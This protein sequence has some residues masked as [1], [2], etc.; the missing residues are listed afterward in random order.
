V[1]ARYQMSAPAPPIDPVSKFAVNV[2]FSVIGPVEWV[3]G[4]TGKI[5]GTMIPVKTFNED[6]LFLI[7][8]GSTAFEDV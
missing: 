5:G 1:T 6:A 3:T 7:V 8:T 2:C 4:A